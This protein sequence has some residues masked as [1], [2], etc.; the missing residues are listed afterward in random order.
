MALDKSGKVCT[1]SS[2]VS[3]HDDPHAVL[4]SHISHLLSLH[5]ISCNI[6][7]DLDTSYQGVDH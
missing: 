2:D 4:P 5:V 7:V 6:W 3:G 1:L